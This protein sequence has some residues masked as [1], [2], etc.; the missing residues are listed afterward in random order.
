M[1]R[2]TISWLNLNT[3]VGQTAKRGNAWHYKAEEQ[4]EQSNHYVGAIP[5]EDV[6]RRLFHWEAQS[7]PVEATLLTADGVQRIVDTERQAIIRP[8]LGTIL[9]VFK[10]GYQ[11]HSYKTWLLDN[12]ATILDDDL[13]I[14]S[15]GLLKGGAVAWVEVS[16][17]DSIETPEGV[18]FRPNLLNT[19]SL[20]GS[21]AT[22]HK[23]TVTATVCDNT[24]ALALS[25][26]GQQV[27]IKHSSKSLTRVGE[28]REALQI[29]HT[30]ADEFAAQVAKLC[31][32]TVTDKQWRS[33]LEAH[34]P[35]EAG[36]EG[37]GTTLAQN[38]RDAL[39]G[40][41]KND[42]RVS[43]WKNTAFGVL[44]ADNTYRH[45]VQTVRGGERVER[46]NLNA[47]TGQVDKDDRQVLDT[48]RKVLVSA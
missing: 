18:T 39:T 2:E 24:L 15:A 22:T 26:K 17:P 43:P 10:S 4:G 3:L 9:G 48:L 45:H 14:S 5:V 46:N 36:V 6:E 21:L 23:R 8:D 42:N 33:F 13:Q 34:V 28:V 44:Q 19:T 25:E 41:W 30:I 27:K 32:A 16:V 12:V 29:V 1:S 11:I 40:L 38:K 47:L 37:R 31:A 7:A 20:D 35:I